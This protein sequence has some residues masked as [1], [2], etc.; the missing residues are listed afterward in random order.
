MLN[1]LPSENSRGEN[2]AII[3]I[4]QLKH[5]R[6]IMW[7]IIWGLSLAIVFII[8]NISYA[9]LQNQLLGS[10]FM[11]IYQIMLW[12]TIIMIPIMFIWL[13]YSMYK[14]AEFQ[15]MINRGVVDN[16]NKWENRIFWL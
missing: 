5:L 15:K 6:K 9:Y 4:S 13:L 3:Q 2:G 12:T 7:G 11:A 16:G 1:K 10:F 14:D 8:A